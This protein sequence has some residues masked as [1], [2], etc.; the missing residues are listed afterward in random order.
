MEEKLG[1]YKHKHC[2]FGEYIWKLRKGT[3]FICTKSRFHELLRSRRICDTCPHFQAKD[4]LKFFAELPK[5]RQ[6]QD[7]WRQKQ[8]HR[9]HK[10]AKSLKPKRRVYAPEKH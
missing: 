1:R 6:D 10:W 7:R 3:S 2:R 5:E 9:R 4:A 8:L